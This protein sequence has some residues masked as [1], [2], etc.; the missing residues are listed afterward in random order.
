MQIDDVREKLREKSCNH[1]VNEPI[2]PERLLRALL[3]ESE[4]YEQLV[5]WYAFDELH[6]EVLS[7]NEE[8]LV[9]Q[10]VENVH[11]DEFN[12]PRSSASVLTPQ[13]L[14]ESREATSRERDDVDTQQ[15]AARMPAADAPHS[16]EYPNAFIPVATS[17]PTLSMATTTVS[18][19][20]MPMMSATISGRPYSQGEEPNSNSR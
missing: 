1:L 18:T 15:L 9:N 7:D 4:K 3:K 2:V 16:L 19:A 5:P 13:N 6:P 14:R 10:G 12:V 8:P 11:A 20:P 17:M